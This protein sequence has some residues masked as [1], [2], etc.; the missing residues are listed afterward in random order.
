M[1]SIVDVAALAPHSLEAMVNI[2]KHWFLHNGYVRKYSVLPGVCHIS[3]QNS[4]ESIS[5]IYSITSL[6]R[7]LSYRERRQGLGERLEVQSDLFSPWKYEIYCFLKWW[8]MNSTTPSGRRI[9]I[10]PIS[11]DVLLDWTS[12]LRLIKSQPIVSNHSQNVLW[13]LLNPSP[14]DENTCHLGL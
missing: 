10:V 8:K 1:C 12:Q 3:I 4:S 2:F 9:H 11:S 13:L 14:V 6:A 7:L 5:L